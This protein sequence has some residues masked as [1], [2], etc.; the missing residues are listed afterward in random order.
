MGPPG[1]AGIHF[2]FPHTLES[3]NVPRLPP[4][5]LLLS[6]SPWPLLFSLP[7][8]P[9]GAPSLAPPLPL[10]TL[11]LFHLSFSSSVRAFLGAEGDTEAGAAAEASPSL[12]SPSLC[13]ALSP[14][15]LPLPQPASPSPDICP[16]PAAPTCTSFFSVS[17]MSRGH[18]CST[19]GSSLLGPR[20]HSQILL[21]PCEGPGLCQVFREEQTCLTGLRPTQPGL[22][23]LQGEAGTPGTTIDPHA[24]PL[25]RVGPEVTVLKT[26]G[27]Q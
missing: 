2:L 18:C 20:A 9:S 27:E 19:R 24:S 7:T 16:P 12:F 25:S 11:P 26:K 23:P 8:S 5:P 4:K 3:P 15:T 13:P 21:G 22:P 10:S 1:P 14:H 17:P 6:E